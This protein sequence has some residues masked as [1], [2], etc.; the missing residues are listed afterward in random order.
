MQIAP[1]ITESNPPDNAPLT[2]Q[3]F[4]ELMG[5]IHKQRHEIEQLKH[6][7]TLLLKRIY[8]PRADKIDPNQMLM[9]EN[10]IPEP[11]PAPPAP[12]PEYKLVKP[13]KKG[14]GRK[15]IPENLRRET[16]V[17]DVTPAEKQAIGGTWVRIG[18]EVSQRLEYTPSSLFIRETIR[19]KYVVRFENQAERM[20][21]AELPPE[22][23]PKSKGA[24][25]LVADVI[26]SK[27]V[28]H[29]PLYRQV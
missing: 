21:V 19:P 18:E 28:D 5:T 15:L 25:G 16:V 11:V 27:L 7:N 29:M 26:V 24:P 10:Q 13:L 3:V 9:F 20:M 4:Q 17:V 1:S 14:H 12:E 8:G 6:Q 22:A 23:M 2:I